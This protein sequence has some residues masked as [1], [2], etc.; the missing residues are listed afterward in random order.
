MIGRV[1]IR[2][3]KYDEGERLYE[4]ASRSVPFYSSWNLE[5]LYF[6]LVCR[7]RLHQKLSAA[8]RDLALECIERGKFLLAH[9][10]SESGMAERYVGRLHQLRGEWAEAIPFL[11]AARPKVTGSDL[12]AVDQALVMSY[13]ATGK[14]ADATKLIE[15]GIQN[16]GEYS[17]LYRQMRAGLT[18]PTSKP[19]TQG[20]ESSPIR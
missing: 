17:A 6:M 13:T 12:V 10:P 14:I 15:N 18:T 1:M 2:Q 19:T 20:A 16:S 3:G 8:D 5:Y 9:S 11:L 4:I 7:E